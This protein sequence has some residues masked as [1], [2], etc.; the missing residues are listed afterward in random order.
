[1]AEAVRVIPIPLDLS[2]IEWQTS[3]IANAIPA[4]DYPTPKDVPSLAVFKIPDL[5]SNVSHSINSPHNGCPPKSQENVDPGYVRR[6]F[7]F[8]RCE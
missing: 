7:L 6:S 2:I 8:V 3:K 4:T 5:Y 1:M